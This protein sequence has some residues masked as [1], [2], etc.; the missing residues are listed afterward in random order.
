MVHTKEIETL[1][2][3][4]VE[5]LGYELVRVQMQG[6]RRPTLQ[7]MAER[8]DRR[9]M[10]VDDCARIS[11]EVSALLDQADPI[12]SEYLLEVSSPGIDRPLIR[13][14]DYDRFAGH[15][16]KLELAAPVE[17]RKRFQGVIAGR[18]DDEVLIQ[19][20]AETVKL[21]LAGIKRARLVLTDRLIAA[22]EAEQAQ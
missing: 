6:A 7:V 21:P 17:G 8:Q 19:V 5:Q 2:L 20:E 13:A 1:I 9:G 15:E 18:E 10:T 16:A 22:T 4:I 3:P 14:Q 11:R 12:G